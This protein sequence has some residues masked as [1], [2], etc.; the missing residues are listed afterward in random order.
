MKTDLYGQRCGLCGQDPRVAR[1]RCRGALP[2]GGPWSTTDPAC[3]CVRSLGTGNIKFIYIKQAKTSRANVERDAPTPTLATSVCKCPLRSA[4]AATVPGEAERSRARKAA[5]GDIRGS[6]SPGGL[7]AM[8]RLF[9]RVE[10]V[11]EPHL[12]DLRLATK[13]QLHQT[14]PAHIPSSQAL[15]CKHGH[16]GEGPLRG[17]GH[18][19]PT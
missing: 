15:C 11:E 14:P 10:G 8:L 19:L 12:A 3:P 16:R 18:P 7:S 2:G 6:R 17:P 13:A 4:R 1:G 5:G 9:L